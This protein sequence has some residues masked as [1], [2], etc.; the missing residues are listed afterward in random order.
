MTYHKGEKNKD[1]TKRPM[2]PDWKSVKNFHAHLTD[3]DTT[4]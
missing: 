2:F 1:K 4:A 3:F